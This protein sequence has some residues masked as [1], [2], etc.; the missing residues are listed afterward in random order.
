MDVWTTFLLALGTALATG[1]GVIPVYAMGVGP[2]SLGLLWGVSAG[3]M[4]AISVL[5]LILPAL[6]Q[7][8][9]LGIGVGAG[10]LFVAIA[11]IY[12]ENRSNN[13]GDGHGHHLA[14]SDL[15]SLSLLLFLVFTVHSAPEGVGIGSA[16]RESAAVGVIV[17]LAIAVHNIPEGTA[18]G[19][20]LRADGV[21]L[22]KAMAAAVFT[23][24]PQP[25]L[26]P[27]VFLVAVGPWLPAGMGFAGGAMLALVARDIVPEGLEEDVASFLVG[28]A[29]GIG[30]AVALNLVFP[31]PTGI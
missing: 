31:V 23:S 30:V 19:V 7:P 3:M 29:L 8:G 2:R 27:L 17:T 20:S 25:L 10:I 24:L 21:P 4:A 5:D 18:V 1:L 14:G 22:Y 13:G 11:A 15:S 12:L 9:P 6:D 16:L 28:V 26:A